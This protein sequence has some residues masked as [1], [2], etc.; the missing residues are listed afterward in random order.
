[1]ERI[2]RHRSLSEDNPAFVNHIDKPVS[3]HSQHGRIIGVEGDGAFGL[4]EK[5][6]EFVPEKIE[7]LCKIE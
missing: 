4:S 2:E 6:V 5:R 3:Q 1:M 7:I